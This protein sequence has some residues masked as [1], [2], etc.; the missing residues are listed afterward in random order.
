VNRKSDDLRSQSVFYEY[1]VEIEE[2]HIHVEIDESRNRPIRRNSDS[3]FS[4]DGGSRERIS[5]FT[6]F[7]EASR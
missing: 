2:Y 7:S 3:Q 5:R 1:N 4:R 6:L